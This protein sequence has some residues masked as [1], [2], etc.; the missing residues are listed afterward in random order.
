MKGRFVSGLVAALG[1]VAAGVFAEE[2]P[3]GIP[4]LA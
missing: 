3:A 4:V 2:K 1:V